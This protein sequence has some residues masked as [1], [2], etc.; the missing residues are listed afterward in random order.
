MLFNSYTFLFF[1]LPVCWVV[2]TAL[3]SKGRLQLSLSWLVLSSLAFYGWWNPSYLPLLLGSVG[4]NYLVAG[5]L[6]HFAGDPARKVTLCAAIVANL[7]LLVYFK[8]AMFGVASVNSLLGSSYSI[9]QILLP[10]GISFFTFQQIAFLVDSYQQRTEV[11][12]LVDYCLFVSFFPQLIAGP[13]VHHKQMMPQFATDSTRRSRANDLAVGLTILAIGLFKKVMIADEMAEHSSPI[14]DSALIGIQPTFAESWIAALSYTFQLYFDF[15]GYSDMAIGIA[16]MFGILLP[17][18]FNSPYKAH[19]I[20]D[21]WRRWH[22]TLSQFLRDYLYIPL[23]GSRAGNIARY[24]NLMITMLLGG[25]WH[26][27]GWTFV[28][29]GGLHGAFLVI[30]H[31]WAGSTAAF[32]MK[33][34]IGP[35][36]YRCLSWGITFVAVVFAW[37]LFR[38]GSWEAARAMILAMSGAGGFE[39]SSSVSRLHAA[40]WIPMLL[41]VV[42][43]LPNTQEILRRFSPAFDFDRYTCDP[44][45]P[46]LRWRPSF[47][48][49]MWVSTLML[50]S[51]L[52]LNRVSEFV[53]YQF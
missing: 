16:R 23:G 13:I 12:R 22:M 37:V 17:I 50:L 9:G 49:A 2:Y 7:T 43:V 51:L 4:F 28:V 33:V 29:W 14:F 35:V 19:S 1:F 27:A 3:R 32:R 20:V 46:W 5:A 18:N 8:Y 30:N 40:I 48:G 45:L 34:L 11:P 25:L 53:Y 10:I 31:R 24:R 52:H 36:I 6:G 21:F 47:G 42:L 15:S 44:L 41:A 39:M 38:C 26:G